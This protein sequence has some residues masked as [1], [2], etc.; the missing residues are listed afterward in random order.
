MIGTPRSTGRLEVV[1]G[2]DAETA[3]VLRQH[4][5][6]AELRREVGDRGGRAA[7]APSWPVLLVPARPGQVLVQVAGGLVEPAQERRVGA[8]LSSRSGGTSP[9]SATGSC[10]EASQPAGS[11]DANRSRESACQDQRRFRVRS[12]SGARDSG[13]AARTVKRRM[14]LTGSDPN[15]R[16]LM[17]RTGWPIT[18]AAQNLGKSGIC[19]LKQPTR[20]P[21]FRQPPPSGRAAAAGARRAR[22]RREPRPRRAAIAEGSGGRP[23][24]IPPP[25]GPA[26]SRPG[27]PARAR[28]PAGRP[29]PAPPGNTRRGR[30]RPPVDPLSRMGNVLW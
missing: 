3:G 15:R 7:T 22:R 11:I 17:P 30:G 1:A 19:Q 2:Q 25:A 28:I 20:T 8:R 14:A 24:T 16:T 4:L 13:R 27:G 10:P 21:R 23:R 6:D 9:S 18:A 12:R 5:G 29:R 26:E